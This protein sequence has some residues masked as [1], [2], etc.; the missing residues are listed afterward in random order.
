MIEGYDS[1]TKSLSKQCTTKVSIAINEFF[2][3]CEIDSATKFEFTNIK[4][5]AFFD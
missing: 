1:L 4:T 5:T 2:A 3:L